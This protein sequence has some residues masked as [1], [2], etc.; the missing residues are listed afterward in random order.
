MQD[1]DCVEFLRWA[2]PRLHLRWRG[3]RRVRRQVCRR[4]NRRL[5]ELSLEDL[6]A[7]RSHL[8]RHEAEWEVLDGL[9]RISIS[10]FHRDRAVWDVL[11]D[12]V[13]PTLARVA[14]ARR[15]PAL[16]A[17]SAG[18][19]SGEEPY[20]LTAVWQLG[21]RHGFPGLALS[22]LATDS[23][24]GLLARA[25][26]RRTIRPRTVS[27]SRLHVLRRGAA[28]GDHGPARPGARPGRGARARPTRAAVARGEGLLALASV[29]RHPSPRPVRAAFPLRGLPPHNPLAGMRGTRRRMAVTI[30]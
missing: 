21:V 10:R 26:T 25:G 20:S 11:R 19:A 9:C 1:R 17:W 27:K 12:D 18:C 28:T 22:V 5:R 30:S 2:L 3:F 16:M 24:P 13:L 23:D 4:L 29:I 7:Y 8:A 15:Q 14:Q 6:E